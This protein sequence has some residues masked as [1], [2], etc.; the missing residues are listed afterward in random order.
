M[1]QDA[2]K[3]PTPEDEDVIQ[4]LGAN[5]AHEP[6]TAKALARGARMGVR[7]TLA[8]SVSNT[9]SNGPE[10]FASRSR[11]ETAIGWPRPKECRFRLDRWLP[12]GA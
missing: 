9:S 10:N 4:T 5:A 2:L 1:S 6:L 3:V 7:I 11:T 12:W 8:P